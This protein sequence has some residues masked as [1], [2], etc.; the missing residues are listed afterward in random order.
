MFDPISVALK[1]SILT[2]IFSNWPAVR[3]VVQKIQFS[4]R[5]KLIVRKDSVLKNDIGWML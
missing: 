2:G 1:P 4:L 3:R 5:L